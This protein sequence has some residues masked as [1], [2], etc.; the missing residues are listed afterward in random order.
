MATITLGRPRHARLRPRHE[1]GTLGCELRAHTL[2]LYPVLVLLLSEAQALSG[3]SSPSPSRQARKLA[4]KA[5]SCH[6]VRVVLGRAGEVSLIYKTD[7]DLIHCMEARIEADLGADDN[8]ART[9]A[10]IIRDTLEAR[11]L[12]DNGR[13]DCDGNLSGVFKV[14]IIAMDGWLTLGKRLTAPEVELA[15]RNR[16]INARS[17]VCARPMATPIATS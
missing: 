7:A 16:T 13:I 10:S 11:L 9:A 14:C 17:W 12:D 5:T 1:E 6:A 8:V 4:L 3:S 15:A 2:S